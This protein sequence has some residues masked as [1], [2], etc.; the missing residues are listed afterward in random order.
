M[1]ESTTEAELAELAITVYIEELVTDKRVLYVGDPQSRGPDRLARIARSVDLVSPR[2]RA[3]GTRR[4]SRVR[5][6]RWPGADDD[7]RWDVV[8]VPDVSA[9]GLSEESQIDQ[10]GAWL[11]EGGV[12]VAGTAGTERGLTYEALFDLLQ[13]NFDSVRM[14]GQA[15]FRGFSLVDFAPPGDLGVTFDGSLL[16][17]AGEQ[18]QRFVALCGDDD[19]VLDAYAVVQIPSSAPEPRA[20]HQARG[21]QDAAS[22][23]GRVSQLNERVRE[24]QD[25]LDAANVHAEELERELDALRSS[26]RRAES[27]LSEASRRAEAASRAQRAAETARD[28]LEG[29]LREQREAAQSERPARAVPSADADASRVEYARLEGRLSESG[30]QLTELQ[31]ELERRAILVRDLIEELADARAERLEQGTVPAAPPVSDK[32]PGLMST[33]NGSADDLQAAMRQQVS[34]AT[35]RAVVA[36]ADKASL[37]FLLDELRGELAVSEQA[38]AQDIEELRRLEAAL[39]GTVRGLNARLAEV[40]ELHQQAQASLA[41]SEDDAEAAAERTIALERELAESREQLE[42]LLSRESARRSA[43]EQAATLPPASAD[44]AGAEAFVARERELLEALSRCEEEARRSASEAEERV[45]GLRQGY[46]ARIAEIV[47]EL[48]TLGGE[49]ARVLVQNGELKA[50][51]GAMERADAQQRGELM[52]TK[53]RLADREEAVAALVAKVEAEAEAEV[54]MPSAPTAVEVETLR[55][56]LARVREDAEALR[57]ELADADAADA[58]AVDADPDAGPVIEARDAMIARLQRELAH[59]Q[60]RY[61]ALESDLSESSAALERHRERVESARVEGAVEVEQ[62]VRELEEL[63]SRLEQSEAERRSAH[64]ALASAKE[65]LSGLV[66]GLSEVSA[67]PGAGAG[68]GELRSLRE[69]IGRLDAQAADREVIM[70]SLTAQLQERDDRIRAL[71]TFD[72]TDEDD[73]QALRARTLELEE[74]AARLAEELENERS[75]RRRLEDA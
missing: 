68:A 16:E 45:A 38:R 13:V 6:R 71:E 7:G 28:A 59:A 55:G 69:R 41:L 21:R 22:D 17:G 37:E 62:S 64:D 14:I 8:I 63:T 43:Q 50:K 58:S 12:L 74:R 27:E 51:L 48:D 31:S 52:G 57:A 26:A 1:P 18:A 33:L 25:A 23:Q 67:E 9:A 56:E 30:H 20:P 29:R 54:P 3:R 36:E 49:S 40:T 61:R 53:L 42:L 19:V 60:D 32:P 73:P 46:E 35:E 39:R 47:A 75:A 70:R 11:A 65:I 5:S 72:P 24:Q 15:P 2:A 34:E 44:G 66:A 4:G 10:V